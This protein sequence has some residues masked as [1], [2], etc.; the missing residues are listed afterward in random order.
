MDEAAFGRSW[1]Q[2]EALHE[3][4]NLEYVDELS[5]MLLKSTFGAEPL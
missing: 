3:L 4:L 1:Q 5:A 2:S